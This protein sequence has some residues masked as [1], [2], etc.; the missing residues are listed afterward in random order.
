MPVPANLE[1]NHRVPVITGQTAQSGNLQTIP[2]CEPYRKR[3]TTEKYSYKV[4]LDKVRK[5]D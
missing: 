5:N 2:T 4:P 1:K 3:E